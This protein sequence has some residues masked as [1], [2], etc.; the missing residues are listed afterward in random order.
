M[1]NENSC[2]KKYENLS[3]TR[4][5]YLERAREAAKLTIPSL[6]PDAGHSSATKL[7]TPY[8]GVGARG[9]NNLASKLLLSLLPPNAPFFAM[10]LDDFT[11]QELA[12]TEGAR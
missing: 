2:A 3:S 10:R 9:V 6:V 12:Q 7:Y 5:T 1:H 11:I 8:Q 4:T